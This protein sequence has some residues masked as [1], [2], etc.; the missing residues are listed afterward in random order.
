MPAG[1]TIVTGPALGLPLTNVDTDQ[2]IPARFMSTPRDQGYGPFL[3]HDLRRCSDGSL[4]PTF[5][6]NTPTA[7]G[8]VVLV[9]GDNL[10]CGSSREAA[11]YALADSGFRG[12]IAPSFG[13]IFYANALKNGVLP[14][15]LSDEVVSSLLAD[16]A[17]HPGAAVTIDLPQQSVRL[18]D[19]TLHRFAIDGF[20]KSMLVDGQDELSLT[21]SLDD[22]ISAYEM[23]QTDEDASPAH[24]C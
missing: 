1:F 15:R 23:D 12:L 7:R 8:A 13:D 20:R 16:L 18:P 24:G 9:T 10:G 5:P 19:G 3:L 11:V 21:L 4:D 22:A 2:L 14:I 6:L 17:I